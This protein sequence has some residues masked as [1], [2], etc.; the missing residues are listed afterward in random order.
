MRRLS[1]VLLVLSAASSADAQIIRQRYSLGAPTA[2]FSLGAGAQQGFS[3]TDGT[4]K[5]TWDFGNGTQYI[6]T[7]EKAFSGGTTV[8][9]RGTHSKVPLRYGT[10]ALA[11]DA[12]AN[13]SQ[14]MGT[15]HVAGSTGFHSVLEL[16]AGAT[17]YSN[18]RAQS[19]G[20]QLTPTS[21]DLDFAFAFGY[22]FGY[23][24]SSKFSIDIV[25]DLTTSI[26]QKTG[27]NAGDD[28]T[29]RLHGTRVMGRFGLGG[30]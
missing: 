24:F 12:D 20:R 29:V 11:T 6:A 15:V 25:Q 30:R 27:L 16:S 21:P 7:L 26:H 2:W 22:G 1:F 4:T 3:V 5:T 17:M 13:V 23:S 9:L 28:S 18:F 14:F 10:S 8:G 19:D